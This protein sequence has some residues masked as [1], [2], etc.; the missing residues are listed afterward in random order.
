MLPQL[1]TR[2]GFAAGFGSNTFTFTVHRILPGE[3]KQI[4]VI[5]FKRKKTDEYVCRR[6]GLG[7]LLA[8]RFRVVD[9]TPPW[10]G[11]EKEFPVI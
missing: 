1:T 8:R 11:E 3:K 2:F 4:R 7:G 10:E 6:V 9:V 5:D